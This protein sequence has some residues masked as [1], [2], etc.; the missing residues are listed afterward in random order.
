M[1][2]LDVMKFPFAPLIDVRCKMVD[3]LKERATAEV[4]ARFEQ[5]IMDGL[6]WVEPKGD[7]DLKIIFTRQGALLANAGEPEDYADNDC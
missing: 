2:K 5:L 7:D 6:I 4:V 3:L 1:E